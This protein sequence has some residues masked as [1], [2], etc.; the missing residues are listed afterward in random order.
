[1]MDCQIDYAREGKRLVRD[2]HT[3][4]PAIYWTDLLL[5]AIVGWTAFV[6]AIVFEPFSWPML[7]AS[8]VAV[9]ALYRGLCFL[10][11]ISHL[12][13]S[14]LRGFETTWNLL[15][16]VPMLMPSI[17]YVGVHQNHH[18]LSTYGTDQDPEYLPFSGRP[19][20]IVVFGLQSFLI[21]A[22]LMVR[23]L[24]LSPF[25]LLSPSLHRWLAVRASAL[26]M[27]VRYRR[28]V[29]ESSSRKM[30][31]WEAATLGA[32][33]VLMALAALRVLPW[34]SFAVWYV[35]LAMVCFINTLRTLGAHRYRSDGTPLDRDGQLIDSI[36]TPGA[37][38]TELWA[39]VG[40]RYHALHHYF[41]G[42]PYHNLNAAYRRLTQML[43]DLRHRQSTSPSLP[44]SLRTLYRGGR[45]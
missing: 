35:V 29:T 24:L 37:F 32:W 11:E 1:M 25:S 8:F 13:Q 14:A 27:N 26:S 41:P 43:P 20:M 7:L 6:G 10:H 36:D 38:W 19:L 34:R 16:G 39:P 42:I 18:K 5:S 23:F 30:A 28:D 12:R 3:P 2:L 4:R 15:F 40:L 17:I 22:L 44:R 33:G 9:F 21:P 45:S 31:R